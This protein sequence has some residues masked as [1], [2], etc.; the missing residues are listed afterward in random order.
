MEQ[1]QITKVIPIQNGLHIYF[2]SN[3]IPIDWEIKNTDNLPPQEIVEK[4]Y[5]EI[6]NAIDTDCRRRGITP[7]HALPIVKDE[8]ISI[9]LLGISDYQFTEG[10][11]PIEQQLRCVGRTLF[12][13][14][15]DVKSETVF[16]PE[17]GIEGLSIEGHVMT[18]NPTCSCGITLIALYKDLRSIKS[19]SITYTS[20]AEIDEQNKMV[21]NTGSSTEN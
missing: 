19:F 4:C 6:R 5:G 13:K 16:I 18:L 20:Q 17:V 15:I 3:E 14:F 8:I 11:Q 2:I 9:E 7:N 21:S 1:V 10:Q 12:N